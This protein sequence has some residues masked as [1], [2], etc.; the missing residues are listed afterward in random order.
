MAASLDLLASA[1]ARALARAS[2]RACFLFGAFDLVGR[3]AWGGAASDRTV[4]AAAF[5]FV[6]LGFVAL[7][8]SLVCFSL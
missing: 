5:F 7:G 2:S 4:C 8:S 1:Q 3:G 6:L